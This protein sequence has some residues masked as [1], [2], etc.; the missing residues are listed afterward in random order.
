MSYRDVVSGVPA[1][2]VFAVLY[3]FRGP[4]EHP[5]RMYVRTEPG[6]VE[7]VNHRDLLTA[8]ELYGWT[9]LVGTF[10]CRTPLSAREIRR[11]PA[12]LRARLAA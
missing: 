8:W 1:L 2:C 10:R 4:K 7:V 11:L 12:G 5:N 3:A 9:G 6:I